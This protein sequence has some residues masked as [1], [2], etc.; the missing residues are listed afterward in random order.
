MSQPQ[1]DE[2]ILT[3]NK[4]KFLLEVVQIHI[5]NIQPNNMT[6]LWLDLNFSLRNSQTEQMVKNKFYKLKLTF[7]GS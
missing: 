1:L 4:C 3:F 2:N 5:V 6:Q 7:Q